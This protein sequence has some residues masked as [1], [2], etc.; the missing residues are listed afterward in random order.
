[1][2]ALCGAVGCG[3]VGI[4][5]DGEQGLSAAP[6]P[7]DD[8]GAG[9][10]SSFLPRV[11]RPRLD[12]RRDVDAGQGTG[13]SV[14]DSGAPDASTA[15]GDAGPVPDAGQAAPDAG[16]ADAGSADAGSA[17]SGTTDGGV[18]SVC[19]PSC[20]CSPGARCDLSC[21]TGPCAVS[22]AS[23]S[24]CRVHVGAA[25]EVTIDC[26]AGAT[27]RATGPNGA[28]VAF[29]CTGPGDCRAECAD[30]ATCSI[31]CSGTGAC[32][33]DCQQAASCNLSCEGAAACL[34]RGHDGVLPSAL[35]VAQVPATVC[36]PLVLACNANCP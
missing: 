8:A 18:G 14:A 12:A 5:L 15:Q 30:A 17:D 10:T 3:F 21:G 20:G 36:D 16:S 32:S 6:T 29:V 1:V 31:T 19:A 35:C 23:G 2:A 24:D 25:P 26:A 7:G 28:D 4:D 11:R 9:G 33:L 27:C 34:V 13:G 22:C